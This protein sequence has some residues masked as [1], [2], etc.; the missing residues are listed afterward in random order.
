MAKLT[1]EDRFI[2]KSGI[3]FESFG[4]TQMSG[5]IIGFLMISDNPLQ[6]LK[7]LTDKLRVAKSTV[8]TALKPM[9]NM[10]L[11]TKRGIPGSREDYYELNFEMLSI[12]N[13]KTEA[14]VGFQNLI[15]EAFEHNQKETERSSL[16]KELIYFYD[17]F[18]DEYPKLFDRWEKQKE[19]LIAEGKL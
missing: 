8:S 6:S 14:A 1:K 16:L 18:F 10:S 17:F 5:R 4:Y 3:F 9:V 13:K 7:Q 12:V 19:M 15:K 2:E 11:L